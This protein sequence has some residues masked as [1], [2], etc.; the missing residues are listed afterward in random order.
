MASGLPRVVPPEGLEIFGFHIPPGVRSDF[1]DVHPLE[2]DEQ[3][4]TEVSVPAYTVQRDVTI[5]GDPDM[6]R[7]ER[8]FEL[9]DK[10]QDLT[11]YLLSFGK[12]ARACVSG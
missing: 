1:F 10:G 5:W 6:F 3:V 9:Q 2:A 12:G 8:W 4:K 7:P 11:Q